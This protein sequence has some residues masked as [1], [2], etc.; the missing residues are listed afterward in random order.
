L[1]T[2]GAS[3]AWAVSGRRTKTGKPILAND[4]H[5]PFGSPALWYLAQIDCPGMTVTGATI[6]GFPL[7]VLGHNRD[8]AWGMTSNGFDVEDLF[9]EDVDP[10]DPTKYLTPEGSQ[11]FAVTR[12]QI[13]VAGAEPVQLVRRETRHGP[14]LSDVGPRAAKLANGHKAVALAY[15]GNSPE[16]PTPYALFQINRARDWPSFFEAAKLWRLPAQNLMMAATDGTIGIV[17]VGRVPQRKGA[18]G[19]APRPGASA[20]FDWDGWVPFEAMPFVVNPPN[21]AIVNANDPLPAGNLRL[22]GNPVDEP[23]R[24]KRIGQ[25]LDAS[26]PHSVEESSAIQNDVFTSEADMLLPHLLRAETSDRRALQAIAMLRNWNREMD[27][28]RPEPLIY[29]G[30]LREVTGRLFAERLG[31]AFDDYWRIR[32]DVLANV[33]VNHPEFCAKA[34]TTCNQL[35]GSS[36]VDVIN[37]ISEQHGS[38]MERW[39][40]GETHRALLRHPILSEVP[41]LRSL[42]AIE[43]PLP[44][45]SFTVNRADVSFAD[46]LRPYGANFGAEFRA[47]Y[48][49]SDLANSRFIISTGETGLLTS[50]FR[51]DLTTQWRDGGNVKI[52]ALAMAPGE[53]FSTTVLSAH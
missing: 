14:V 5:T 49:L 17:S 3:N 32:P 18:D 16:D 9:I 10:D 52:G 53:R 39:R 50:P 11:P 36:L 40:W 37:N 35:L 13:A 48:D 24:A 25:L 23:F 7:V 12:Q 27:A 22:V 51:A 6:P 30:W 33:L 34:A 29:V 8:I 4:P 44:G 20:A 43:P 15:S 21:G 31:E 42:A 1:P 41:M 28:S 47:V 26:P 2:A 19:A 38:D 46:L 45:G